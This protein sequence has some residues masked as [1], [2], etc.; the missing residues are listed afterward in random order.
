MAFIGNNNDVNP[1]NY[2]IDYYAGLIKFTVDDYYNWEFTEDKST[3]A[4]SKLYGNFT[5]IW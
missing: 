1:E 5:E 2:G 3:I 4:E